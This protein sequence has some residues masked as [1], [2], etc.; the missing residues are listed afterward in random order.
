[1]SNLQH[2]IILLDTSVSMSDVMDKAVIGLN[3]FISKLNNN[4]YLT[5]VTFD[6]KMKYIIKSSKILFT[7]KITK[8]MFNIGYSTLLYDT[9][10]NVVKDFLDS[11][12]NTQVH[13]ITDGCDNCSKTSKEK[14]EYICNEMTKRKNWNITYYNP[15]NIDF[16]INNIKNVTYNLDD[17]DNLLG[18]MKI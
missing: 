15:L 9:I 11:N 3:K 7:N 6:H 10:T 16:K 2:Y 14:V 8:S 4:N 17:I 18:N 5:L 12:I 1:M 13:I